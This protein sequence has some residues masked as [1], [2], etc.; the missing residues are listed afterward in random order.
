ML[1]WMPDWRN[2]RHRPAEIRLPRLPGSGGAG[3]APAR[4]IE[5]DLPTERL[6]A[7]VVVAKYADHCRSIARPRSWRGKASRSIGRHWLSGPA[8]Q[9]QPRLNPCGG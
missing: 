7:D 5:G 1:D 9:Q 3:T 2:A 8:T 6:V 4:L